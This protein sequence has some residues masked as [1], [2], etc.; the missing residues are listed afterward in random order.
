MSHV[1]LK[2]KAIDIAKLQFLNVVVFKRCEEV[3]SPIPKP[4]DVQD[5]DQLLNAQKKTTMEAAKCHYWKGS[6]R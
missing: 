6:E 1:Y 2:K 5:V 3:P 4:Q